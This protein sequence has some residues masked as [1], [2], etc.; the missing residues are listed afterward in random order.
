[1]TKENLN[2]SVND[3]ERVKFT[4]DSD[5]DNSIVQ[6]SETNELPLL[7]NHNDIMCALNEIIKELRKINLYI[8]LDTGTEITDEDIEENI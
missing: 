8:H 2:Y 5:T 6:T 7:T 1:M 3:L 4:E